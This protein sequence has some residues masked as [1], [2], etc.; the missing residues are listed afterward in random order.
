[1]R[2][3]FEVRVQ[4]K[5]QGAPGSSR[6]RLA[7]AAAPLQGQ[8]PA[9][10]LA[11]NSEVPA[12]TARPRQRS[13]AAVAVAAIAVIQ[14]LLSRPD[15]AVPPTIAVSLLCHSC[16]GVAQP[17]LTFLARHPDVHLLHRLVQ[18]ARVDLQASIVMHR[19]EAVADPQRKRAPHRTSRHS[20]QEMFAVCFA[21]GGT[22]HCVSVCLRCHHSAM[23][24]SLPGPRAHPCRWSSISVLRY[25]SVQFYVLSSRESTIM[26]VTWARGTTRGTKKKGYVLAGEYTHPRRW[27]RTSEAHTCILTSQNGRYASH[28]VPGHED[29]GAHAAP[30]VPNLCIS[31]VVVLCFRI[32]FCSRSQNY[33]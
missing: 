23:F 20:Q 25:D 6:V 7:A 1:M 2:D 27:C 21:R 28:L 13:L 30:V 3:W 26:A 19:P 18:D 32:E 8:C 33:K 11:K 5:T 24:E 29:E 15:A 22:R 16:P 31:H 4:I 17:H 14:S 9:A 10:S 12:D